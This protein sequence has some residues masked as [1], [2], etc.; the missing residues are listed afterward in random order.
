MHWPP[1]A[2]GQ[3]SFKSRN[4][5]Y[6]V[7]GSDRVFSLLWNYT[8]M[9]PHTRCEHEA[10]AGLYQSA[11]KPYCGSQTPTQITP[12]LCNFLLLWLERETHCSSTETS[13]AS[14][15]PA[16]HEVTGAAR[17]RLAEESHLGAPEE[18]GRTPQAGCCDSPWASWSS[19][20]LRQSKS[21]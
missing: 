4:I 10:V 21:R 2:A 17:L 15:L 3:I 16:S 13:G 5:T 12:H 8:A 6:N 1:S 20:A 18:A 19:S 11:L 7:C 9:K 14:R